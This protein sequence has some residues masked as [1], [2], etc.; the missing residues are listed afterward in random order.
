MAAPAHVD[1]TLY[2]RVLRQAWPYWPYIAGIFLLDLLAS[3]LALLTPLP[4]KIIVDS[5]VGP[6]LSRVP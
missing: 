3:P 5:A 2:R 1:L 4:L 6:T